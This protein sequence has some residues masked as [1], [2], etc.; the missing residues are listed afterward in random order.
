MLDH[1]NLIDSITALQWWG[2]QIVADALNCA[3][4]WDQHHRNAINQIETIQHHFAHFVINR[5]WYRYLHDSIILMLATLQIL[6]TNARLLYYTHHH[7]LIPNQ[8]QPTL[9]YPITRAN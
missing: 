9:A 6:R 2:S 1:F 8:Y 3:G 4:I 5:S 7:Q